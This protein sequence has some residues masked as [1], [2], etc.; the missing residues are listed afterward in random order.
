MNI[1]EKIV[2]FISICCVSVLCFLP[3]TVVFAEDQTQT[4]SENA[5]ETD[6][7]NFIYTI[8]EETQSA[9][10]M[11]Y[12]GEEEEVVIPETVGVD[13]IKVTEIGERAFERVEMLKVKIPNSVTK[14]GAEAFLFCSNLRDIIIPEGV[15]YIDEGAFYGCHSVETIT[16]S[17]TVSYIGDEAFACCCSSL[18]RVN[19]PSSVIQIGEEIFGSCKN[20]EEI[21]VASENP[22]YDSRDNCNAI[23][24]TQSD[25]IIM[26]CVGTVIPESIIAIAGF[27]F[28]GCGIECVTIPQKLTL[29]ESDAFWDCDKLERITVAS[30]NPVY[31]SR[32]NC[33]AIIVT[34][35]NTLM[36]GSN[37]TV[38]PPS[39]Q[40]ISNY[41]FRYRK[42]LN[43]VNIPTSVTEV[44]EGAFFGCEGLKNINIMAEISQIASYTF[45]GCTGLTTISIPSSVSKIDK[46][47][48]ERCSVVSDVNYGGTEEQ[49]NNLVS[50]IQLFEEG[51]VPK[52]HFKTETPSSSK[53]TTSP[54]PSQ[55]TDETGSVKVQSIGSIITVNGNNGIFKVISSDAKNPTVEYK[56]LTKAGKKKKTI[57]IPEY[58]SYKGVKYRVTSVASKCFKNN[59]KL[60]NV[61][62]S[63][64]ITKIGNSA[65]EGCT[66]LKT[67]T[68]G[69]GLKT[70]GKNA[71]K[72]CK[73]LKKLTLKSTKLKSVGKTAMKVVNARCKIKVPAKKV[74]AYKK[75][76]KG[77]GQKASV[78]ITK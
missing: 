12:K 28:R 19:I 53:P 11:G 38:I 76:F 67:A 29:I 42:K 6:E 37:I 25:E 57:S 24:K 47:A 77:K 17:N 78:K 43:N 14:I 35:T 52:I 34:A 48:F 21:T 58:I 44:G 13:K 10:I 50:G 41:A 66:N 31:D 60:T 72:N 15:T 16:I 39:V 36:V 55:K 20:L 33:N 75:V 69:K 8:N 1:K 64:S 51:V 32:N 68:I 18:K 49:W 73:S 61:K 40:R 46:K 26:G 62:I 5:Q 74:T 23:V 56:A 3:A 63:S 22:V 45:G 2:Y 4:V 65:F 59:K 70:I 71:F 27:A 30:E 9:T 54:I 7:Q